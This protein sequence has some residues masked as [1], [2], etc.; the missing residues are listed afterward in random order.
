MNT[1]AKVYIVLVALGA[2]ILLGQLAAGLEFSASPISALSL[3]A[4]I[5]VGCIAE[6]MA[7]DFR[8]GPGR[9]A[10]SS[11]A[12]L[13]FLSSIAIFPPIL[14]VIAVATVVTISQLF[15]RRTDAYRALFNIAQAALACAA[16]SLTYRYIVADP[17]SETVS[18]VGFICG[19]A[20]FF[21]TNI[22]LNSFA[23]ALLRRESILPVLAQ[24]IGSRGSN[25]WYD[26]LA[27][28]IALVPA[29]LYSD[30]NVLGLFIIVL[31]L[32]LIRYTYSS[33]VKLEDASRDLMRVLVKAIETRDP[34]TSGH[35]VRVSTLA[36]LVAEDLRLD[37]RM[38]RDVE[39]AALL[40]DIGKIDPDYVDLI[41]KP[42]SLDKYERELI[43]SHATK[44]AD[45]LESLTSVNKQIIN[46][47][48]HHHERFDGDGYPDGLTAD[49]IPMPARIIMLCD[50]VDAMLSDRPYRKALSVEHARSELNRCAG[51]Q[52]D[53]KIVA[54][55]LNNNTLEKAVRLI[56]G[57]DSR[58]F[59]PPEP[60][61]HRAMALA[62]GAD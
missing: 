3:A 40:H 24:V 61:S 25:L 20:I 46:A 13:P 57:M 56:V 37:R 52:F 50:S 28:P 17:T 19:A 21:M 53:P 29:V 62:V 43:R 2:T 7:V 4:F 11:L 26:L 38:V 58:E 22:A 16:A 1:A 39:I 9:L 54:A 42:H 36:K 10:K 31:P 12:F 6:G 44:G 60:S 30:Y 47:V 14:A 33:I 5:V 55:V 35:S 18:F 59:A 15:I 51:T 48:R 45:L 49:A 8:L 32:L 34:Y 23:I 41:R 27:S